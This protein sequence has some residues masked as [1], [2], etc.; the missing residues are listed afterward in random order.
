MNALKIIFFI[1][2]L[3]FSSWLTEHAVILINKQSE[4]MVMRGTFLLIALAVTWMA[5]IAHILKYF[6]DEKK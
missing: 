3:L 4:V 1:L 6:R 2:A 5:I